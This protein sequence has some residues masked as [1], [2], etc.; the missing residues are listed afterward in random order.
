MGESETQGSSSSE[1]ILENA[2]SK[3]KRPSKVTAKNRKPRALTSKPTI[4]HKKGKT[5]LSEGEVQDLCESW[6]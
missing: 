2:G 5:A 1:E 4:R 3:I 6:K